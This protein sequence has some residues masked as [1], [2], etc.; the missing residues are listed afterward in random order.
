M[1]VKYEQRISAVF[2]LGVMLA[3]I[4][5]SCAMN[6]A[7]AGFDIKSVRSY[8]DI[9]GITEADI[10]GIEKLKSEKDFFVYGSDMTMEAFILPDGDKAGFTA[11]FCDLLSELFD[12][13]FS[14]GFYSWD[15]MMPAID[16][17]SI[18]FTGELTPTPERSQSYIMSHPITER[19][20][21]IFFNNERMAIESERDLYGLTIGFYEG[22]I[23]R[24]YV[25]N[26][27]P[28]LLSKTVEFSNADEAAELLKTGR[29]DAFIAEAVEILYYGQYP[30]ITSIDALPLVY[31]PVSMTTANPELRP[32]ISAVN[33]YLESGGVRYLYELYHAGRNEFIKHKLA[34][35]FTDEEKAYIE[36]LVARGTKAP[37]ALE[38]DNYPI[39]FFDEENNR[40][41]GIVPDILAE[42]SLL[43]GIEFE[44]ITGKDTTFSEALEML[45]SGEAALISQLLHTAQWEGDYIW[46][47]E[48]FYVS[49]IAFL[50]RIDY[51]YLELF[52]IAQSNVGLVDGTAYVDM[53]REWFP[54]DGSFRVYG[55][56]DKALDA[57]ERGEIDLFMT[58]EYIILYQTNFREKVGFKVNVTMNTMPSESFFGFTKHEEIL[59]DIIDK[60]LKNINAEKM[61][62]SWMNRT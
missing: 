29:M 3:A 31:T 52:Q 10:A 6:P 26:F 21:A 28:G 8:R 32:V 12:I 22:T 56:T 15:E 35:S 50:S 47:A 62:R 16:N 7:K 20:L 48:P 36:N 13:P 57:L 54:N 55:T 53:Y 60:V 30:F 51:P 17:H 42:V 61:T 46:T 18:D 33:K 59:R 11:M 19:T 43:T 1:N 41:S 39:C 5:A 44:A 14:L 27:Y 37:V 45:K 4:S 40:F 2:L 34:L 25:S 24:Q 58:S 49:H 38:P 23:T 9:P